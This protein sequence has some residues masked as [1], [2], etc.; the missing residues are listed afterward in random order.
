MIPQQTALHMTKAS[1]LYLVAFSHKEHDAVAQLNYFDALRDKN[2]GQIRKAKEK[3]DI[4][5]TR[6]I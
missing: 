6:K 4:A 2:K 3:S 5:E 1:F